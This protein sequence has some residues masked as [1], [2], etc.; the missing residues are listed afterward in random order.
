ME[1]LRVQNTLEYKSGPLLQR[2]HQRWK[3]T[4]AE[5][6]DRLPSLNL[7]LKKIEYSR[8]EFVKLNERQYTFEPHE[9]MN[10]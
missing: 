2:A 8:G 5:Q 9:S 4:D 1:L 10:I 6:G 7:Y 3:S